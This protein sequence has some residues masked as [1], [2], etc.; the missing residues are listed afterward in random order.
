M[1]RIVHS[2]FQTTYDDD[3]LPAQVLILYRPHPLAGQQVRVIQRRR[4]GHQTFWRV[5]LPDGSHA[6]LPAA[7]TD[8]PTTES[9]YSA[10]DNGERPA[11]PQALRELLTV[12]E[13]L[14]G[15]SSL[16]G[17]FSI[18]RLVL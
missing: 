17:C 3:D 8:Q 4:H 5:L 10:V 12:V 13:P 11:T 16:Y 6:E 1:N 18:R 7:W 15:S 14:V 9:A 2:A